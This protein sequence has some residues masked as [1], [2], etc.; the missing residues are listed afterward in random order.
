ME[1][2]F[3][4]RQ[5]VLL[6]LCGHLLLGIGYIA[7][8]PP[9]EGFD[10]TAHYSSIQQIAETGTIP[11]YGSA[12]LSAEVEEY[13]KKAPFPYSGSPPVEDNG[14]YTY[15][16][17][18]KAP[19]EIIE[20]GRK[21]IRNAPSHPRQFMEGKSIN[22]QSQHPPL[23][24]LILSP[25]YSLTK[26]LSWINQLFILR[27]IS[28]LFAWLALVIGALSFFEVMKKNT[29]GLD[30]Q[31]YF[32]AL[33]GIGIWPLI[34]PS[35]FTDMARMGND[36]LCAFIIAL[37][38]LVLVR[39]QN[40]HNF[41]SYI[42]IGVLLG[43]GC[44]IKAFF[45]PIVAGVVFYLIR[46]QW[47]KAGMQGLRIN[48]IKIVFMLVIISLIAGWW[49]YLNWLDYGVLLGSDEMIRLKNMGG[50]KDNFF[51]NVSLLA[52]V[53]GHAAAVTT[54][55]WSGSWSFARPNYIFLAPMS[56]MVLFLLCVFGWQLYRLPVTR[57][58]WLP[59]WITLPILFG[60]S[61]HVVVRIALIGEGRGTGGYYLHF[62]VVPLTM[63]LGVVLKKIWSYAGLK[64][65]TS[66]FFSYA[67]AF[68]AIMFYMQLLLFSGKLHIK[69]DSKFYRLTDSVA[70]IF[71]LSEL[72]SHLSVVAF[73]IIGFIMLTG[74]V[75]LVI[76]GLRIVSKSSVL[77]RDI[78]DDGT[79]KTA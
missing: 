40:K 37:L 4:L 78:T 59:A 68:S 28:F 2:L 8:L 51:R 53:R 21:F 1:N 23:Y 48:I 3:S 32:K 74:G 31:I 45:I 61:Y 79:P 33:I 11:R 58:E 27:S 22:W 39:Y 35:W 46:L 75:I 44:L 14:G 65:L 50:A 49:Y 17:F 77:K 26:T 60:L 34:F 19:K 16:S 9:W 76:F 24:Y 72:T 63:A 56:L 5:S 29:E 36:S 25:I 47:V 18:F 62:L 69:G 54:F 12:Y 6:I 71:D 57:L 15:K 52:W 30:T 7:F 42:L 70:S 38:W 13:S 66:I 43:L 20:N 67:V 55:A 41:M 73:P 64:I 10:E